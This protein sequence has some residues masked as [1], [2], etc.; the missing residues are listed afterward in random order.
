[1]SRVSKGVTMPRRWQ[2]ARTVLRAIVGVCLLSGP[3]Y[4]TSI[5]V[6][7]T[8]SGLN[9]VPPNASP[10][11]GEADISIIGDT[12]TVNED[13]TGLIGGPAA[14]AHIH[15]CV[16]PGSN[17]GVAVGFPGFPA[18]TSGAYTHVFNLL[19]SSI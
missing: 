1:M 9:E 7:T 5:S 8:L 13:W 12:L 17:I 15:C 19:Y 10:A 11:T 18:A 16:A 6:H 3:A 4:A 2:F 14:A